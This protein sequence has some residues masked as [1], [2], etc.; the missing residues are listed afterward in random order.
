MR[1]H[2]EE[3]F[4]RILFLSLLSVIVPT[5]AFA[6]S[7][8]DKAEV[9]DRLSKTYKTITVTLVSQPVIKGDK[10]PVIYRISPAGKPNFGNLFPIGRYDIIH[11]PDSTDVL[12]AYLCTI[13][14]EFVR[15]RRGAYAEYLRG[16]GVKIGVDVGI[17]FEISSDR[18][19]FHDMVYAVLALWDDLRDNY[20]KFDIFI[21]GYADRGASF[22]KPLMPQYPYEEVSFLPLETPGDPLLAIYLRKLDHRKIGKTYT[23]A[24]LPNLRATFLKHVIDR[25]LADC[26]LNGHLTPESNVLDGGVIGQNAPDYRTVDLYF[27]AHQ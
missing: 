21:R 2:G 25:F 16:I 7:D 20:G 1:C 26:G 5:A 24:D 22:Q 6:L 3:E 15:E 23:N 4:M 18:D 17:N 27:Y 13:A 8:K 19:T 9:A 10:D 11:K 12:G 14:D